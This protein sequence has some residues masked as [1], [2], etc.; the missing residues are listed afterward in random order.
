MKQKIINLLRITNLIAL[1]DYMR[2]RYLIIKMDKAN[3]DV[4]R[5]NDGFAFPPYDVA[6]DA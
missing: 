4:L 6:Y 3:K 1:V 2:M 5:Q